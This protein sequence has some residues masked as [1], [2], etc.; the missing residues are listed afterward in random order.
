M[1]LSNKSNN[2]IMLHKAKL[3]NYISIPESHQVKTQVK[4]EQQVER[5]I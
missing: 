3:I 1:N 2:S 4:Y 5:I